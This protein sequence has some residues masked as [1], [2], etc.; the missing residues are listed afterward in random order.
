MSFNQVKIIF[1]DDYLMVIDKAAGLSVTDEGVKEGDPVLSN[2]LQENYS[3]NVDR[4]G[5]VHRLDKD[6]SGVIVVGKTDDAVNNLK[7]QFQ[8][9]TV[10]KTYLALA[11]GF[12][13]KEVEVSATILRNPNNRFKFIA[14]K[15]DGKEA[16]TFFW[17]KEHL[18]IS[19]VNI[20][21]VFKNLSKREL[22]RIEAINYN[23]FSLVS[24]L[25]KTGRTHQIRVHLK[26][27]G[28]PIVGDNRYSGKFFSRFDMM[29]CPRQFLHASKIEFNHPKTGKRISFESPL[30]ED[31]TLVMSFLDK[32]LD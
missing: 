28:F 20:Q 29:W 4:G 14:Q 16:S 22:K 6:T 24:C 25:P 27:V 11:H 1:Q 26:Y 9:R 3:I 19:E 2:I 23:Q 21:K 5:V 13:E 15:E 8:K 31:L 30:P 7:Q 17:P 18:K 10:R 32:K 12:L